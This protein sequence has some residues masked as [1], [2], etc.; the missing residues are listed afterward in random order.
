MT[1]PP[2]DFPPAD[3]DSPTEDGPTDAVTEELIA[4]SFLNAAMNADLPLMDETPFLEG[5][6]EEGEVELPTPE[7]LGSPE[8]ASEDSEA[9]A[10]LDLPDFEAEVQTSHLP[11][12]EVPQPDQYGEFFQNW[13]FTLPV[14]PVT[15]LWKQLAD[16]MNIN[17]NEILGVRL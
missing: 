2:S 11:S 5:P 12:F 9:P 7:E 1:Q 14:M 8:V 6:E 10:A 17:L 13:A 16:E 3:W 15:P 4:T